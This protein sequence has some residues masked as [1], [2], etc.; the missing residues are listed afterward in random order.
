[1]EWDT[2]EYWQWLRKNQPPFEPWKFEIPPK[3]QSCSFDNFIATT[4]RAKEI[5]QAIKGYQSGGLVLRGNPGAGKTHLA[6]S[7]MRH[8]ENRQFMDRCRENIERVKQGISPIK[9]RPDKL[10]NT[11]P[12]LLMEIRESFKDGAERTES[13]IV[14]K[15]SDIPLLVLDDLGSEKTTEYTVTTLYILIDRRDRNLKDTIITTNLTLDEIEKKLSPRIAS[16]LQGWYNIAVN[17]P[18]HRKKGK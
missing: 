12:D 8:L 3:Y 14:D 4:A 16:R 1:M 11:V 13:Q 17:L 15:Y 10:F 18:D 9:G 5:L 7:I 2:V 6:I